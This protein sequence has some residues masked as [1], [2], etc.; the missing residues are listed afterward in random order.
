ML[1]AFVPIDCLRRSVSL[2][3]S[4]HLVATLIMLQL[5]ILQKQES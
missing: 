5:R 2:Q 4:W 3:C 1:P